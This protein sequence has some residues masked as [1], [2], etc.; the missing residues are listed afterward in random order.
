VGNEPPDELAE[1]LLPEERQLPALIKQVAQPIAPEVTTQSG[2]TVRAPQQLIAT[3]ALFLT[4]FSPLPTDGAVLH[5]L[6]PDVEAHAEPRPFAL[7]TEHVVAFVGSDPDTMTLDEALKEP[8]RE[9]FIAAMRKELM[10]RVG[11]K[12]W[13]VVP[14]KSVPPHKRSIPMVWSTKRKRNPIGEITKW[15][16]RLCAGG[17]RSLPYIDY[18]STYSPVVSWNT[19]WMLIVMALLNGWQMWSID[20]VLA[21]PQTPLKPIS[22]WIPQKYQRD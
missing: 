22:T 9:Q 21:F 5:L 18:W 6:Q 14:R 17:H 2:R 4:I 7:F 11:R 3:V 16:A 8:D 15:K 20:F 13:K 19:V 1:T 12:H 10:D